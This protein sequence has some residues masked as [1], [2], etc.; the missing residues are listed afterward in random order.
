[1]LFFHTYIFEVS[2][3]YTATIRH[4]N[5][6]SIIYGSDMAYMKESRVIHV[7]KHI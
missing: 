6:S 5:E 4:I 7:E 1:M 2:I 3:I